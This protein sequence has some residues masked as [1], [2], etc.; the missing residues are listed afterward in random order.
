M[1]RVGWI[2][3]TLIRNEDAAQHPY[4][5]VVE[6]VEI[7]K[8]LS[9]SGAH[10]KITQCDDHPLPTHLL[11]NRHTYLHP[12][13]DNFMYDGGDVNTYRLLLKTND[14]LP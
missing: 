2:F 8:I 14:I 1:L 3:T 9:V 6:V 12:R 10:V 7:G 13:A 11:C 5:V 4:T